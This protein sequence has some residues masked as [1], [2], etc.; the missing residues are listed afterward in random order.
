MPPKREA[1][2][3]FAIQM[4]FAVLHRTGSEG[5]DPAY[6]REGGPTRHPLLGV[7]VPHGRRSGA[8]RGAAARQPTASWGASG[9]ALTTLFNQ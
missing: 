2:H 7:A 6:Q 9:S 3:I 1:P 8:A 5:E 4:M